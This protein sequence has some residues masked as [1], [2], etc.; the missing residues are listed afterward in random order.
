MF[1]DLWAMPDLGALSMADLGVS[2][3]ALGVFVTFLGVMA[4]L[5]PRSRVVRRLAAQ[6]A[7]AAGPSSVDA[8]LLRPVAQS[9]GGLMKSL[10]PTD[11][12][13]RSLVQ[14]QL[15]QAGIANPHA[16]RNYYLL[17][18][19]LGLVLPAILLAAIAGT[20]AGL[21]SLPEPLG[22]WVNGLTRIRLVQFT[23]LLVW[24]G[25][26]GPAYWLRAKSTRRREA[27]RL[28]FPNALDLMQISVEAGLGIDAAMIRVGNEI[29]DVAPELS[30]EMLMTQREIQAGRDRD[31]AL[32]EMAART[33]LD[34]VHS[35]VTVVLQ[36]MRFGADISDV[37]VTYANEMRLH[38]ELQAQEKANK[39]PVQ[40]SAVMA[41]LMLPALLILTIGPV[42]LRY[43]RY[44]AE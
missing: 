40:M 33:R 32:L 10:I 3:V 5:S 28:A 29:A 27:I 21:F 41:M 35:F 25:F 38:R 18:L 42:A 4:A 34:E 26:F 20:Q 2:G 43:M 39:L 9:P 14:R 19:G 44:F 16:V 17:R 15:T 36:S 12:K 22:K 8:G 11:E 37:L 7:R 24:I 13:E 1:Q 31:S 6:G 23:G 30:Q